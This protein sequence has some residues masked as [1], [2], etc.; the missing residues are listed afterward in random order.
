[1]GGKHGWDITADVFSCDSGGEGK[2]DECHPPNTGYCGKVL[3][4]DNAAL[5]TA[6]IKNWVDGANSRLGMNNDTSGDLPAYGGSW[7]FF[8]NGLSD[9]YSTPQVAVHNANVTE[10]GYPDWGAT[11]GYSMNY[12]GGYCAPLAK[13]SSSDLADLKNV[14]AAI[15]QFILAA[16]EP[17]TSGNHPAPSGTPWYQSAVFGIIGVIAIALVGAA[18]I[19]V[20]VVFGRKRWQ[21]RSGSSSANTTDVKDN[22]G[23]APLLATVIH[24]DP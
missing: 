15:S 16:P 24:T 20:A 13:P 11:G 23:S 9:P 19:G 17:G 10:G 4:W 1:M 12:S 6:Q 22:G 14:R 3:D 18:L 2:A 21:S 5:D 7:T 8:A